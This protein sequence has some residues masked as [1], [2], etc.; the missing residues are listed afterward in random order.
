MTYPMPREA[1]QSLALKVLAMQADYSYSEIAKEL[2][3]KS[4][5]IVAGIVHR[6]KHLVDALPSDV[7][8]VRTKRIA[9]VNSGLDVERRKARD[10]EWSRQR[11]RRDAAAAQ[12]R[13]VEDIEKALAEKRA[14]AAA[15]VANA[16]IRAG[17]KRPPVEPDRM[18]LVERAA[19]LE[20]RGMAMLDLRPDDCRWIVGDPRADHSFCGI[21]APFGRS[22]CDTHHALV[23]QRVPGRRP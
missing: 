10:R 5:N 23:Y 1:A 20:M 17:V 3:L 9:R 21:K 16:V 13:S 15:R 22:Y 6:H 8:K 7:A 11:R 18:V 12:G 4:R 14:A 19:A 2:G